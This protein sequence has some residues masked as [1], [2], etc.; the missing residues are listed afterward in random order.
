MKI[1][2]SASICRRYDE[3]SDKVSEMPDNT[4]ALVDLQIYLKHS[5]DVT[6]SKLKEEIDEAAQRLHFLLD[7]A[8]LPCKLSLSR[9]LSFDI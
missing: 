8:I 1:S 9:H 3:M 5:Q 7:Y 4:Q 6:V 2:S